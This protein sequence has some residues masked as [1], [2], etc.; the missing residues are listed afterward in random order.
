MLKLLKFCMLDKKQSKKLWHVVAKEEGFFN[1]YCRI[2]KK[3]LRVRGLYRRKLIKKL[4][5]T[6]I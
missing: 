3:K 2:I 4:G 5:L 6:D 1:L